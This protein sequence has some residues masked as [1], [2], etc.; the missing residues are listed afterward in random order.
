[1]PPVP[2][3]SFAGGEWS[4]TLWSRTDLEKYGTALRRLRNFVVQPEGVASN[5]CGTRYGGSSKADAYAW[6][7]P[8]TYGPGDT[9]V[10]VFTDHALQFVATVNGAHGFVESAPGVRLEYATPWA[11][12][13][14]PKLRLAQ[15]G[16]VIRVA[17]KGYDLAELT[18]TSVAPLAFSLAT[19]V[20]FDV[21]APNGQVYLQ[22]V[23]ALRASDATHPA[24][25]WTWQVTE[26]WRDQ[27]GLTWETSP[28]VVT[29]MRTEYFSAWS[30]I[31][32]Y[33]L[34]AR[35]NTG[36]H[37]Y[38]SLQN[39]NLNHGV[40]D[41]A[42]WADEGA[43][44]VTT[45]PP[46]FTN[47]A[48]AEIVLFPDFTITLVVPG[49][50]GL[51][52]ATGARRIGRR[53]YRGRGD[54][55]GYVGEFNGISFTDVG[56]EPV[57]SISP[58]KGE[59]PF[60]ILDENGQ[61]VRVEQPSVVAYQ[62]QRCVLAATVQRP[63]SLWLSAVNDYSNFDTHVPGLPEDSFSFELASMQRE[64]LRAL[65]PG[66]VL[67]AF[68]AV[69]EWAVSGGGP[70]GS[71]L[72]A[73]SFAA[74]ERTRHG[75]SWVEPV[76]VGDEEA[77]F[78]PPAGN[79]VRELALDPQSGKY[80]APDLTVYSRHLF[81]GRQVVW[82]AWQE[83]PWRILWLGLDDG[84]LVSCTYLP[85]QQLRAWSW[86]DLGGGA[87]E[88]GC[89][90]REGAED[91]LYLSVRRTVGGVTRR[92]CERMDNRATITDARLGLF[93]D[94]AV[95]YAGPPATHLSGLGHLEGLAVAALADGQVVTG[96][97]VAG[98]AVD[99]PAEQFPDGASI[100]HVG[101]PIVA[102][103]E[104]LD[105]APG[106]GRERVK[107]VSH[108]ILEVEASRGFEVGQS[109]DKPMQEWRQRTVAVGFGGI[110]LESDSVRVPITSSWNPGGRVAVRHTDPLPLTV[111]TIVREVEYGGG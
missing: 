43:A 99:L 14:L 75:S 42:W 46:A 102:E 40:G 3:R 107:A 62:D 37:T 29:E 6:Y 94:A 98:G 81:K 110:P 109:L 27:T 39:G 22:H 35:V 84:S 61:P 65:L 96:L 69:A 97:T 54:L 66:R 8:F 53:V 33:P 11:A 23:E 30:A 83:Q 31:V 1:M 88:S 17:C 58:P 108:A 59:N 76:K 7:L 4:P 38:R 5:R 9:L 41:A 89:C 77:L 82:R 19:S 13:D 32:T 56:D 79:L 52:V 16:N 48:P 85:E 60:N 92:F 49:S 63:A 104:T 15:V 50:W 47:P 28:G 21:P 95:S 12:A 68:G 93:L 80:N 25:Q 74:R 106:K 34:N 51:T 86:H 90:V 57:W 100:V 111:T 36:G 70:D 78:F 103:L 10:L 26:L 44:Y 101:I 64:E 73:L 91:A 105:V 72:T 24:R 2:Q 71:A 55:F 20:T 67:F 45:P 18:R 87:A